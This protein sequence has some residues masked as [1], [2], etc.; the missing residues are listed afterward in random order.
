MTTIERLIVFSVFMLF[1][2]DGSADT[3]VKFNEVNPLSDFESHVFKDYF[4]NNA[5]DYF[6]LFMA[7]DST[8]TISRCNQYRE[9]FRSLI[10]KYQA[11]QYLKMKESKRVKKIYQ[12][13]HDELL[14]KYVEDA[15]FSDIFINGQYQCVTATMLYALIFCKL[16]IPFDIREMPTHVYLV[17]YPESHYTLVETTNPHI[18]TITYT[19]NF[20]SKYVEYLRDSKI[21]GKSEY[22]YNTVDDL[23]QKHF[24]KNTTISLK[25]LVSLQYGN[26]GIYALMENDHKLAYLNFEKCYLFNPAE[27]IKFLL[28]FSLALLLYQTDY[29]SDD[30]AKYSARLIRMTPTVLSNNMII[31]EFSIIT[32]KQLFL[33]ADTEQYAASY[34]TILQA[35]SD[36]TLRAE[37]SFIYTSERARFSY[38][39]N[40]YTEALEFSEKAYSIKP[41]NTDIQ[42]LYIQCMLMLTDESSLSEDD[43]YRLDTVAR[44]H[45]ELKNNLFFNQMR[46]RICLT[47]MDQ[48]YFLGNENQAGDRYRK[49]F[50]EEYP[51]RLDNYHLIGARIVKAYSA[52]ASYYFKKGYYTKAREILNKGLEYVPNNIELKR[53]LQVVEN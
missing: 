48:A 12:D 45:P 36:S 23:F 18:G 42:G 16:E 43:F 3:I 21:I 14:D 17:A 51:A 31:D 39:E 37:I 7:S 49:I 38:N 5:E 28:E 29:N 40:N 46:L 20:K 22:N 9:Q 11:P 35:I 32:G 52:G 41:Q 25:E 19:D 15:R 53:R 26:D 10:E 47:L 27:R 13:I 33:N 24:F 1:S 2:L 6:T 30:Y 44:Q 4:E 50:E 8:M 34:T